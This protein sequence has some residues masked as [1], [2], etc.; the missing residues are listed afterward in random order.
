MCSSPDRSRPLPIPF[1]G[2]AGSSVHLANSVFFAPQSLLDAP[3]LLFEQRVEGEA[4]ASATLGFEGAPLGPPGVPL[5]A[6]RLG[7]VRERNRLGATSVRLPLACTLLV[8]RVLLILAR[9]LLGLCVTCV[10]VV[11]VWF[12]QTNVINAHHSAISHYVKCSFG[13]CIH[14][15]LDIVAI[16]NTLLSY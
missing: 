5:R 3:E 8:S 16:R 12:M 14:S 10:G 1:R 6:A 9:S 13:T 11:L 2:L 15:N 4:E 7:F